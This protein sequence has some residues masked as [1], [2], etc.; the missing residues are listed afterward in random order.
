[1]NGRPFCA[2]PMTMPAITLMKVI[3]RPAEASPRTNLDAPS[4]EPKNALSSSS[5]LRRRLASGSSI[6]PADRS[7]SI[8][9][10]LPGMASRVKRAAT[11]AIRPDP[12]V[13]TTKLTMVRIAKTITPMTKLPPMT[14]PAKASITAPAALGPS[15]PWAR[16][17]R[18]DARLSDRR[19][20]VV[21][22]RMV[23]KELI[24]SGFW[25]NS[26]VIRISTAIVIDS[27]RRISSRND[28]IGRIMTTRIMTSP[29]ASAMSPRSS[30]PLAVWN[31]SAALKLPALVWS[32]MVRSYRCRAC[33]Q[34]HPFHVA[35]RWDGDAFLAVLL[36]LVAQGPDRDAKDGRRMGTVAQTVVQRVDDQVAFHVGHRAADQA[37]QVARQ[38]GRRGGADGRRGRRHDPA[39][40]IGCIS[41]R[42]TRG[43]KGG[44]HRFRDRRMGGSRDGSGSRLRRRAAVGQQDRGGIDHRASGQQHRA[45]HRV[46]QLADIAAPLMHLQQVD[47][48][49]RQVLLRQPVGL[50][51]FLG[52]VGRQG[53]DVG[54]PLAQRRQAQVDDVEAEIKV[55][56]EPAGAR[57]FLQLAVGRGEHAESTLTGWL[58]PTRSIS[59]SWIA[60]SSFACRRIS[61][62]LISSSSRVPP[63]ASSNLPTRRATAPV[64]APFS[65]PNSSLSSR[66]SGM[67]AQLTATKILSE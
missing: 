64:K 60:R 53:D 24:S 13:M 22:S 41:G 6:M 48:C 21:I 62:S 8:A 17:R 27:A 29:T 1:M 23:G 37:G 4:I 5:S 35:G 66:C 39:A 63:L 33:S 28:G 36:Q 30:I 11:S 32:V 46:F 47:G 16:I 59:R 15:W 67:A 65:W 40:A 42:G 58:P 18:V 10:C 44:R 19:S 26:T 61:I 34:R 3:I 7:A 57:L 38:P 31:R 54:R 14:K 9:I 56:A 49:R 45:V 51:V 43:G 12:L 2:M 20:S 55:F 50:G 25:M 52:E